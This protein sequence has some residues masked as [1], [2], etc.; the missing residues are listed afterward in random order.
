MSLCVGV[1]AMICKPA[2]TDEMKIYLAC[3][4]RMSWQWSYFDFLGGIKT[5]H[6]AQLSNYMVE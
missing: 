3:V 4:N 1:Y 6:L 5:K 2:L